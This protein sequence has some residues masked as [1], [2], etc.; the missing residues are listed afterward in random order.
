[1]ENLTISDSSDNFQTWINKTFIPEN[2]RNSLVKA[3]VLILPEESFRNETYPLFPVTTDQLFQYLRINLPENSVDLCIDDSNYRELA[4][5]SDYKRIGKFIVVA[6]FIPVFINCLS[7]YITETY[8][9]KDEAKPN[10]IIINQKS[11]NA[12]PQTAPKKYMESTKVKFSVIVVDSN[13]T[14]KEYKYE[15]PAKDVNNVA[16]QM[17]KLSSNDT[18]RN[19]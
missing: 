16:E 3:S 11:Q 15:G 13:G 18:T 19:N 5:H 2:L 6:A 7:N 10:I 1:M 14:S 9:K 17:K 12:E 4:L 8:I